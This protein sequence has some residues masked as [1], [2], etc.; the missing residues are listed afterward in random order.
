MATTLGAA[1]ATTAARTGAQ[2]LACQGLRPSAGT[3]STL[4]SYQGIDHLPIFQNTLGRQTPDF[5]LKTIDLPIKPVVRMSIQ[6]F[7][8]CRGHTQQAERVCSMEQI[9]LALA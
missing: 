4:H 2:V 1:D 8:P 3:S 7:V 6:N 9:R 5:G